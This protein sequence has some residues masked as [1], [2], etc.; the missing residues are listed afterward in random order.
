LV[1]ASQSQSKAE[2]MHVPAPTLPL[3]VIAMQNFASTLRVLTLKNRRADPTFAFPPTSFVTGASSS[4]GILPRLE[5]LNLEGCSLGDTVLV[6]HELTDKSGSPISRKQNLLEVIS[7]NFPS[8]TILDLSYNTVSSDLFNEDTT[9][10]LLLSSDGEPC[11]RRGLKIL[12]LRGNRLANLDVFDAIATM[13]KGNR[14][15][16]EWKLEEFDVRDNNISKLPVNLGLLPLDVF[17]VDGNTFRVPPRKVWERE[18]TKGLS[19]WLRSRI[20]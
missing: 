20:E 18:G 14:Q 16:P 1:T 5:E 12:R 7:T 3:N 10:K 2:D 8:L 11:T 15:V 13:F 6:A 9:R 19:S 4:G 17:L